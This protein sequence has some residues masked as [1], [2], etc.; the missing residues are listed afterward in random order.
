LDLPVES[1]RTLP[2]YFLPSLIHDLHS[3][4]RKQ[5]MHTM[6]RLG[7]SSTVRTS[8]GVTLTVVVNGAHS[9]YYLLL[10][11]LYL[12]SLVLW[13]TSTPVLQL[14]S[15]HECRYVFT[16]ILQPVHR[17]IEIIISSTRTLLEYLRPLAGPGSTCSILFY[18]TLQHAMF[19]C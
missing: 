2:T 10:V 9:E 4:V 17:D 3:T 12:E 8:F 19:L 14:R 18:S 7:L 1:S 6:W 15:M 11:L 13:R 5:F 16:V